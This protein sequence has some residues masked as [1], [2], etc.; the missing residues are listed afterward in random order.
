MKWL[1]AEGKIDERE[2]CAEFIA[3]F[4]IKCIGGRIYSV[5]GEESGESIKAKIGEMIFQSGIKSGVATKTVNLYEALKLYCHS[6]PL[7]ISAVEIHVQNG[8]L[9]TN[10]K[11]SSQKDFCINRL[12]VEYVP[13]PGEPKHF[14]AYLSELLENEDIRTLQ[15]YLGYCLIP[16]TKGQTALFII[17]SGGEGKSRIG[18]VLNSIFGKAMLTGDFHRVESDRFFRY[19]L[20]NKLLMVDDDMQMSALKSTGYVKSIITA[21]TPI[22][23]EAKGQQSHQE[24]LY[25]RFLC[26]GNGSPKALYD[27]SEGF[28]RRLLILTTKPKPPDRVNDPYIADKFIIEKNEIF[29]WI[30]K[31]LKRLIANNFRFTVSERARQNL[32][33]AMTENCNIIQFLADENYVLL[34]EGETASADLYYYYSLWARRNALEPLKKHTFIAWLHDNQHRYGIQND[35]HIKN[36]FGQEVR[37]FR[38]IKI[39]PIYDRRE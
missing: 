28:A 36:N 22:D 1:S 3:A 23:V 2:F 12:N 34:G 10:G 6:D 39:K 29:L 20:I 8:I 15:E 16:S 18:A 11:F 24:L 27:K 17:G 9:N 26:F 7:P 19:N 30:F 5:D 35:N 37:G 33:D 4:P 14:L 31:G 25:S 21:E 13:T 32:A 38:G